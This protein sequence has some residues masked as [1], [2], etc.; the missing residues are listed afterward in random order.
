MKVIEGNRVKVYNEKGELIQEREVTLEDLK[1]IIV[2]E[3]I[4]QYELEVTVDLR[5]GRGVARWRRKQ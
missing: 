1:E 2:D 4:Q 3:L 5:S